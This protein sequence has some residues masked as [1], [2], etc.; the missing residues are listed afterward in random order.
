MTQTL[1]DGRVAIVTGAAQGLGFAVAEAFAVAGASVVLADLD[2]ARAAEAARDLHVGERALGL[3]CDVTDEGDVAGL[4]AAATDR[5]GRLDVMVNNAG[6]TSDSTMR[7]MTV[8]AFELV[9]DVNLK[10]AWLGTRAAAGYMRDH[11][12]GSIINMSSISGKAGNPGQTNYSAAKA[13][14]IGLTKAAA[15]EVGFAGVRVNALQPGII[16][17]PMTASLPEDIRAQRLRDVPLGRFGRPSE[18]AQAA[19]FLASDM[20]S[21]LTGV[22]IEVAGGRHI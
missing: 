6:V 21:Y 15:K 11:G 4:I 12:G 14:I 2:P 16:D 13:G 17:T 20:S 7:K 19:L 22:T 10:G 8:A 1:L 18:V 5:F 9:L 3:R